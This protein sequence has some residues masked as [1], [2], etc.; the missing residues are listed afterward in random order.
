MQL[1]LTGPT[2]PSAATVG[3]KLARQVKVIMEVIDE[4]LWLKNSPGSVRSICHA[5]FAMELPSTRPTRVPAATVRLE[6]ARRAEG[7]ADELA[8]AL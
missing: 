1:H 3:L 7:M 8:E 6:Q 4:A 5:L 2:G